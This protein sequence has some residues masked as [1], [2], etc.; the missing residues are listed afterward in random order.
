[1]PTPFQVTSTDTELPVWG[2]DNSGTTTQDGGVLLK[3]ATPAA[4]PNGYVQLYSPD[5]AGV[6]LKTANGSTVPVSAGP[7]YAPVSGAG[8]TVTG[9]TAKTLLAAGQTV[10]AGGFAAGQLYKFCAWG[11]ITSTATTDKVTVELFLGGIGG[12]AL[13]QLGAATINSGATVTNAA[14]VYRAEVLLL[15]PTGASSSCDLA[16]NFF[17]TA[18]SQQ[19]A[20][21]SNASAQAFALAVTPS[22]VGVSMTTNGAYCT[23]VL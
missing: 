12:T 17:P 11:T 1:M 8:P 18:A 3:G 15:T 22:A 9:T 19:L 10:Q 6:S 2:V 20:T 4:V 14:W 16:L 23:R 21:I 7:A 5:G 13:M